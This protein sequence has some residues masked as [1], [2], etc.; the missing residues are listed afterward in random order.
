MNT[1]RL[2]VGPIECNC[3]LVQDEVS[4]AGLVIDPGGDAEKILAACERERL[5]PLYI[6]NTH[7]H[8]DHIGADG[9]LK[10]AHP[11]ARLCIGWRD[12]KML[13]KP[14]KNLSP[15]LGMIVR[16][17]RA[18]VLLRAGDRLEL[19]SC[20][21][22]VLE[23][24]GHTPGSVC[25]LAERERPMV[26]FC[27]DLVFQGGVGRTDLP[28]GDS[29]ALRQS[30]EHNILNLP[31]DTVLLPGHGAATTVGEEKQSGILLAL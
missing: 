5:K 6:V 15:M 12:E 28:G 19:G 16:A 21:L 13:S 23:T 14:V 18:E 26:L 31:D 7:G 8:G 1:V 27:G 17:P 22:R 3:Y 30:I 25:L 2:I 11:S 10:R 24:P 9:E 20:V 4:G 29:L